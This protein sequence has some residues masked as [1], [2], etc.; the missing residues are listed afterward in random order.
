MAII[1][2]VRIKLTKYGTYE[3]HYNNL[4]RR[5]RRPSVGPDLLTAERLKIKFNDWLLNGKDPEIELKKS[6]MKNKVGSITLKEFFP[7][8]MKRHGSTKSPKMQ[9]SYNNS[10]KNLCKFSQLANCRLCDVSK[11]LVLDYR[12]FR[13]EKHKMKNAT[14]NREAAFLRAMMG[15]AAEWEMIKDNPLRYL[16]QLSEDNFREVKLDVTDAERLINELSPPVADIIEFAI[17]TG[18]R[19][20]NI[21]SLKIEDVDLGKGIATIKVKRNRREQFPLADLAVEVLKRAIGDRIAGFVF[22]NPKTEK[23]YVNI[24]KVFDTAV[25]K[26]KLKAGESKL[27]IHDLRHVFGTWLNQRGVGHSDLRPLMG[28]RDVKSTDRYI[29]IDREHSATVLDRLP[30]IRPARI[31]ELEMI[32]IS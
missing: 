5:R 32:R 2:I 11:S 29:T 4:N 6:R 21:L 17:Y 27:R 24:N 23:R 15:C 25:N 18:F 20:E 7:I 30:R 1:P 26:L 10:F 19:K 28:H 8:F 14:V 31:G 9:V 16:K 3:L 12:L 22:L 13:M